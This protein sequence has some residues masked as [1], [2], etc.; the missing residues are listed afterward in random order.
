[1]TSRPMAFPDSKSFYDGSARIASSILESP[2]A[3][4]N[5]HGFDFLQQVTADNQVSH[6][7]LNMCSDCL[8]IRIRPGNGAVNLPKVIFDWL[9]C[10]HINNDRQSIYYIDGNDKMK[11]KTAAECWNI[12]RGELDNAIDSYVPMKK[13]GKRSKKKHLSKEAFRKI[14]YKQNMWRVY[15]H[16]GKDT[17]YDAYKEALNAATNEVRK[18]KRNF[19]HKL[20]QNIK[21]ES[22]SFY[23]YVRSKQNVRDKVGPLKDNAGNIITQGFLMAE[24]LNMHFSSVFTRENTS[25]LPVPEKKFNGSEGERL[26]QLVVTPEVV[27]KLTI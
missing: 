13:Q 23:A 18:S 16:T 26:G 21:S 17:D 1:M 22:K 24:E 15:K 4:Y 27:A 11:N 5:T 25:S 12:V 7:L 19:E 10:V 8:I 6:C 3:H 20:A 14:R 2:M 9:Q